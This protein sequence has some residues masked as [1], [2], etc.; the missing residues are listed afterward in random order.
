MLPLCLLFGSSSYRKGWLNRL[1]TETAEVELSSPILSVFY[2]GPALFSCLLSFKGEVVFQG[3]NRSSMFVLQRE[4][5]K[6]RKGN[7]ERKTPCE[8]TLLFPVPFLPHQESWLC[9]TQMMLAQNIL[10]SFALSFLR[11][12][13][14]SEEQLIHHRHQF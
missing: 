12:V 5:G 7:R 13:P 1:D 4:E 11:H 14:V 9:G 10:C 8:F 2:P 6:E 3:H